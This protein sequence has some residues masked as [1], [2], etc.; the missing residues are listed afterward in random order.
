MRATQSVE[1][2]AM[3]D[4]N[5][6]ENFLVTRLCHDITGP[7]SAINQGIELLEDADESMREEAM[8]LIV[9]SAQQAS[10]RLQFYRL[11]YGHAGDQGSSTL[12]DKKEL[13]EAF[14]QPLRIGVD[15]QD[16]PQ[17]QV[18]HS[19]ARLQLLALFIASETMI[20]GGTLRL[21][22]VGSGHLGIDVKANQL[23]LPPELL[24]GLNGTQ[25]P[26]VMQAKTSP[27]GLLM[28]LKALISARFK[29]EIID[30][31]SWRLCIHA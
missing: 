12:A 28:Q 18:S 20:R 22:D 10:V 13:I 17:M 6:A 27:L 1:S 9:Q 11:A 5:L 24:D 30:E 15:W 25:M 2:R 29:A 19:L 23:K 16:A 4:V 8:K 14:F 31:S 21:F 7:I 3:S 26:D